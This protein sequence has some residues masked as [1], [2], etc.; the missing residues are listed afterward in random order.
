MT[1]GFTSRWYF[2]TLNIAPVCFTLGRMTLARAKVR[3]HVD[4]PNLPTD[5]VDHTQ[6]DN[7][8]ISCAISPSCAPPCGLVRALMP[9]DPGD[10]RMCVTAV[11]LLRLHILAFATRSCVKPIKR[12]AAP[13]H[14]RHETS[15]RQLASTSSVS[16]CAFCAQPGAQEHEV[17][18]I[19]VQL[20]MLHRAWPNHTTCAT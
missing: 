20:T 16:L 15:T 17:E 7:R 11:G 6:C 14:G 3:A 8:P 9:R 5:T 4:S 12:R 2:L 1:I 18:A 10:R 13:D 19:S